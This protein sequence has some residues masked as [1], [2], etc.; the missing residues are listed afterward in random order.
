MVVL[1]WDAL[2]CSQKLVNKKCLGKSLSNTVFVKHKAIANIFHP[3]KRHVQGCY[4]ASE[5]QPADNALL[6]TSNNCGIVG[7]TYLL[8]LLLLGRTGKGHELTWLWPHYLKLVLTRLLKFYN[9]FAGVTYLAADV[10]VTNPD[11][12]L[13]LQNR[14]VF[15]FDPAD[16]DKRKVSKIGYRASYLLWLEV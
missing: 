7:W 10:H 11:S 14:T 5:T 16:E 1:V 2:K 12:S 9:S 6:C 15:R 4:L 3:V 13:S 8:K